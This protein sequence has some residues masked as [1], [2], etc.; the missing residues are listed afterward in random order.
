MSAFDPLRTLVAWRS[1][2]GDNLTLQPHHAPVSLLAYIDA[3]SG[4]ERRSSSRTKLRL[5]SKGQ[6]TSGGSAQVI[7]HD[8]SETGLLIEWDLQL[9]PHES[10][11]VELPEQG[12]TR[13]VIVWIS[14][15][16]AGCQFEVAIAP[17]V[18]DAALLSA[19]MEQRF[20][21][22][23]ISEIASQLDDLSMAVAR[24]TRVVDRAINQLIKR[25]G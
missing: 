25:R 23:T 24:M 14:G 8:I 1:F 20:D 2:Q 7:I 5:V 16:F 9:A 11:D 6:A 17:S 15:H 13:A 3:G 21:Q 19:Q 22:Q 10:I 18:V 4:V 12:T